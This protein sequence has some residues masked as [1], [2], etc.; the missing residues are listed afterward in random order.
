MHKAFIFLILIFSFTM[1]ANA[2]TELGFTESF[3]GA[4]QDYYKVPEK[5]VVGIKEKGISEEEASVAMFFS[6]T[7][8]IQPSIVIDLRVSGKS[9]M[10]IMAHF[11]MTPEVFY[12]PVEGHGKAYGHLRK[13]K[14]QWKKMMLK[15][16]DVVNLVNL[17]FISEYYGYPP[18]EVI[19]MREEGRNFM[20]IAD[21]IRKHK[22]SPGM[23]IH[24]IKEG[25]GK[26][27][28]K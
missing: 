18:E 15:D 19:R 26:D 8:N 2:Q 14:N 28:G 24:K 22:K 10:D 7:A 5:E 11:K 1:P 6:M 4:M 21:T 3:F 17:K 20:S 9:W 23:K 27:K 16:V 12:V 25:K 13:P